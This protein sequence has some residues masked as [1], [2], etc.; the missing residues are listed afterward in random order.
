M[1]QPRATI[2]AVVCGV[3]ITTHVHADETDRVNSLPGLGPLT[4]KHYSGYLLL[5]G[6][7][8]S[9]KLDTFPNASMK[10]FHMHYYYVESI[11]ADPTTAPLVLWLNG[12]PG[13]SSMIGLWTENGPYQFTQFGAV[14]NNTYSWAQS[15]NML[16]LES[17]VGVGFSYVT[18]GTWDDLTP[19]DELTS[20]LNYQ[21][22]RH[23]LIKFSQLRTEG[24]R[25]I[26]TGESY[27]G[28]YIPTLAE[29]I[30]DLAINSDQQT[31]S[32]VEKDLGKMMK[33]F[34]VG[35]PCTGAPAEDPLGYDDP[36]MDY[37]GLLNNNDTTWVEQDWTVAEFF[38]SHA[39]GLEYNQNVGE[40]PSSLNS[41][42]GVDVYDVLAPTCS[43]DAGG[44]TNGLHRAD[45]YQ[46]SSPRPPKVE[47]LEELVRQYT[48]HLTADDIRRKSRYLATPLVAAMARHDDALRANSPQTRTNSDTNDNGPMGAIR[49]YGPCN[50]HYSTLY[51]NRGDVM[52]ALNIKEEDLAHLN[53][54]AITTSNGAEKSFSWG[55]C[56]DGVNVKY[57]SNWPKTAKGNP[58]G[59]MNVYG[60]FFADPHARADWNIFMYSGDT[61][62]I[63]N[64][65]QSQL[66]VFAMAGKK[67]GEMKPWYYRD[68]YDSSYEQLGG[69]Y[70]DFEFMQWASVIGCGHMVPGYCPY[71]GYGLFESIVNIGKA[72]MEPRLWNSTTTAPGL[73]P[74]NEC[75]AYNAKVKNG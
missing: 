21:S 7:D 10:T 20:M 26:L 67:M 69:W 68:T 14:V 73:I 9:N 50:N 46:Q 52:A 28:H 13:C 72:G 6:S 33:G 16:Y 42:G 62:A 37:C 27:A 65:I 1:K 60:K 25:L 66:V 22:L 8:P 3:V 35:N 36:D 19:N 45:S 70:I 53:A 32:E 49:P 24:R 64:F 4:S 43:I 58:R 59:V 18:P 41:L 12:G 55:F 74:E 39:F 38:R 23:F 61:D 30:L 17:P 47:T 75:P 71:K 5:D 40:M 56:N 31:L 48:P 2:L 29:R 44:L 15:A 34:A 54:S 11:S 63:V 57:W 51:I